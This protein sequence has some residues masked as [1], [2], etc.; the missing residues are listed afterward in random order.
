[1]KTK[2]TMAGILIALVAH[3]ASADNSGCLK[4]ASNDELLREISTRLSSGGG[5]GGGDNHEHSS[6]L[7]TYTCLTGSWGTAKLQVRL[8]NLQSAAEKVSELAV[9]NMESC[10]RQAEILNR[11]KS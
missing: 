5:D 8:V 2:M 6:V 7:A 1:M 10:S 11:S 9:V 3:T 4:A